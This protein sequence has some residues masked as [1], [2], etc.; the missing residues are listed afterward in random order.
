MKSALLR[1]FPPRDLLTLF[2]LAAAVPLL[3]KERSRRS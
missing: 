3:R 1:R 2:L